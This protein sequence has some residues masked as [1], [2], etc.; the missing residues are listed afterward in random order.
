MKRF[1]GTALTTIAHTLAPVYGARPAPAERKREKPIAMIGTLRR[2][3]TPA[4]R[5]MHHKLKMKLKREAREAAH[6][7][8][9]QRE[10]DQPKG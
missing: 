1:D 4:Q 8:R 5:A 9:L 3:A 2:D 6:N 7:A 10:A